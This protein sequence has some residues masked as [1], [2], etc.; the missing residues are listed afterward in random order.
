ML[1]IYKDNVKD[2]LQLRNL[3]IILKSELILHTTVNESETENII[4]CAMFR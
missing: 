3:K 2:Y 1:N 4:S